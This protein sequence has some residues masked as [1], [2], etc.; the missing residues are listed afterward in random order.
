MLKQTAI[1]ILAGAFIWAP[2]LQAED[3]EAMDH[4]SM[5]PQMVLA[6]PPDTEKPEDVGEPPADPEMAAEWMAD[7]FF[8]MM[9]TDGDGQLSKEEMAPWV[10]RVNM[11]PPPPEGDM[12]ALPAFPAVY[13]DHDEFV[14]L[15]GHVEVIDFDVFPDS[16]PVPTDYNT[17][18]SLA[19]TMRTGDE[20]QA[21]GATFAS[22]VG[23]SLRTVSIIEHYPPPHMDDPMVHLY[24]SEPNSLSIGAAP[25]CP[26]VPDSLNNGVPD[27]NNDSLIIT[28]DP[29]RAAVGFFLIDQDPGNPVPVG[30]GIIFKNAAGVVIQHLQPLPTAI[31]PSHQ[32]VG[33]MSFMNPIATVEIVEETLGGGDS[34]T[35]DDVV[36]SQ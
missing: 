10:L 29:P 17:D 8:M 26:D 13:W 11:P 24:T 34:I 36:L 1:T 31:Y 12:Q 33:L 27:D 30:E 21:L 2:A 18:K 25:Y 28:L 6:P 9:D 19:G 20:W 7:I 14:G 16:S 4:E 5:T 15:L 22:P 23:A 35:I 3:P 32:F